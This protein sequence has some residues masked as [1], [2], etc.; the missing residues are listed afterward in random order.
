MPAPS[1]KGG[2]RKEEKIFYNKFFCFRILD[3]DFV[4]FISQNIKSLYIMKQFSIGILL[5][6][7][8]SAGGFAQGAKTM[9]LNKPDKSRGLAVMKA[10]SE[11]KSDREFSNK[12]LNL[13]DLS[14]L[15][16]AAN[17]INR[18]DGKRTAPSAMNKQD[19]EV[20]VCMADGAY[21]YDAASHSLTLV[22]SGDYRGAVAGGQDFVTKAPVSLVLVSD[23]SK[24]SG[25]EQQRMLI[26]AMDAGI[27]SQN[28]AVFCAGTGL[29][30][31]PRLSMDQGKLRSALKLKEGQ[32]LM[33]NNPVGYPVK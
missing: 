29:V 17:G 18:A 5:M 3:N 10:F 20:Y 21:L 33:M 15:L 1:E 14:D 4:I 32:K 28:I 27:V 2:L 12:A 7:V 19:I 24:F 8:F 13:Q 25:D 23:I 6:C 22:S 30:T 31:V 9:K 16:W 26:G 11:R